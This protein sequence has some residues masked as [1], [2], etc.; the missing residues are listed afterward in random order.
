MNISTTEKQNLSKQAELQKVVEKLLSC[1]PSNINVDFFLDLVRRYHC[2]DDSYNGKHRLMILGSAIPEELIV[3]SG[4]V[5]Y[6]I[7]G[8][9]RI[10]SALVDDFV[11]RDTDPVSRAALGCLQHNKD[12]SPKDTLILIPLVNDSTRKLAAIL[13]AEGYRVHTV[14][15]PPTQGRTSDDECFRQGE[16]CADAIFRYT[17]HRITQ[18]ELQAAQRKIAEAR[19]QIRHFWTI[20]DDR[21][22]LLPSLWRLFILHSYYCADNLEDWTRHLRLLNG[23][24]MS[25]PIQKQEIDN[26]S[27]LLIGSPVH[28]PNYKL[29]FLIHEVNLKVA[30]QLDDTTERLLRPYYME[31]ALTLQTLIHSFYKRDCSSAYTKN[32]ALFEAVSR[33]LGEKQIDG[34]VYHVLKGQ[35]EYDFELERMD[36]LF[37]ARSI[38]VCRLET[39]YHDQDIE[40]L[41]IRVEAFQEVIAQRRFT[42]EAVAV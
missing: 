13:K 4:A 42:K 31:K 5:P 32:N 38:P 23:Q 17:G 36:E 16:A 20:T 11:P 26:G 39:D 12:S 25:N 10:L 18:R 37:A 21:P 7:L 34:V 1:L 29:P 15:I 41:R 28:F 19:K 3:A 35:I 8:G 22:E 33:L 27:V 14:Y 40:Q 30:A 6:W 2:F 24:L 9:S